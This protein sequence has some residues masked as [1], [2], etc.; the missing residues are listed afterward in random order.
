MQSKKLV[1]GRGTKVHLSFH[2]ELFGIYED[3]LELIFE[4]IKLRQRFLIA[5]SVRAV[6]AGPG[7]NDLLPKA[8]FIPRKR[9]SRNRT[10]N[11]EPGEAPPA[12]GT[13]RYVVRLPDAPIPEYIAK[14]LSNGGSLSSIFSQ[15]RTSILPRKLQDTT[16]G[17]HFK[18]LLWAEEHRSEYVR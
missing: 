17:R 3:R 14:M 12:L 11:I 7:Y 10:T 15:F 18:A 8:P 9:T 1:F 13:I 6:V 5:R 4:D 2:H 16:Y